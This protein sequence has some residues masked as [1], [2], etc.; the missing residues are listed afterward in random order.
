MLPAIME[1]SERAV[2]CQLVGHF[3]ERHL[4]TEAQHGKHTGDFFGNPNHLYVTIILSNI[5]KSIQQQAKR[6]RST[7]TQDCDYR[8]GISRQ[9]RRYTF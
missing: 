2:Q 1:L 3:N 6:N 9:M 8:Q 7:D 5:I 4:F